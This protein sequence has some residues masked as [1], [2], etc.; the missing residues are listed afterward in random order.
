ML[1][2]R[3]GL[4]F[5]CPGIWTICSRVRL[6]LVHVLFREL[7]YSS[8]SKNSSTCGVVPERTVLICVFRI[9]LKTIIL[10]VHGFI[11]FCLFLLRFTYICEFIHIVQCHFLVLNAVHVTASF[12]PS[13]HNQHALLP[14]ITSLVEYKGVFVFELGDTEAVA[15]VQEIYLSIH[16]QL[17]PQKA[18]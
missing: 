5:S 11:L 14:H 15:Q 12:D 9:I 2:L 3:L 17:L 8:L 1:S 4:G 7:I 18:Q 16:K 13:L 6:F 10:Q